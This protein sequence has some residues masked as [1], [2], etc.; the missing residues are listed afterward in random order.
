MFVYLF[1]TRGYDCENGWKESVAKSIQISAEILS[2]SNRAEKKGHNEM[3]KIGLIRTA[4][5]SRQVQ[6]LIRSLLNNQF[7]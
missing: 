5:L 2:K 4:S 1:E 6:H 7:M 3:I